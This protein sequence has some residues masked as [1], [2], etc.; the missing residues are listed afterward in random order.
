MV[1]KTKLEIIEETVAYYSEDVFRRG[2]DTRGCVYESVE[3]KHCAVGRCLI[4]PK[5]LQDAVQDDEYESGSICD[6][7]RQYDGYFQELFKE[8]YRGHSF[9]F[10]KKLQQIHDDSWG[11]YWTEEGITEKG[12]EA[13]NKLKEKYSDKE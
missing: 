1:T 8:E 4:N 12:I 6:I 13:V 11:E 5:K 7:Y 2:L 9:I 10:W 3:G